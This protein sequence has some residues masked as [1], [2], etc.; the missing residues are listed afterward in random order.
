MSRKYKLNTYYRLKEKLKKEVEKLPK[1]II[2]SINNVIIGSLAD[3]NI[4]VTNDERIILIKVK[5]II[6]NISLTLNNIKNKINKKRLNIIY[7]IAKFVTK[8]IIKCKGE[9]K[10]EKEYIG[11]NNRKV[12]RNW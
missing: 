2:D 3:K 1:N 4:K 8:L 5:E 7:R 11:N 9:C 12:R 6:L 10:N